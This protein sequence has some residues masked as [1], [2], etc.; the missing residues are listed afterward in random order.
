MWRGN[1]KRRINPEQLQELTEEQQQRLREWWE[2][3][4]WDV[5]AVYE[6]ECT[7][8]ISNVLEET[9]K[10]TKN[11]CLPLLD[12]GQM[13][14]LLNDA[15]QSSK[16]FKIMRRVDDCIIDIQELCDALWQAV[17]QVL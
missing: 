8:R 11:K 4:A 13:I 1:M 7:C 14:E 10:T 5:I 16:I 3:T 15:E 12:I 2:L 9:M 6:T 17:K